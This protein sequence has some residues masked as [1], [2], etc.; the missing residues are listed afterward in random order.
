MT[1]TDTGAF[2]AGFERMHVKIR[3]G[4]VLGRGVRIREANPLEAR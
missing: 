3:L 4:E 1:A 2:G